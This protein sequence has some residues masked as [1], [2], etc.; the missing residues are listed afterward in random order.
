MSRESYCERL[1]PNRAARPPNWCRSTAS[2]MAHSMR[3]GRS[4]FSL[5][6]ERLED[7]CCLSA[8]GDISSAVEALPAI[9]E[10]QALALALNDIAE[11]TDGFIVTNRRHTASLTPTG[12]SMEAVDGGPQWHWQL[13]YVGSPT[14]ALSSVQLMQVTPE[15]DGQ[16]LVRYD[17]GTIVEQY[18]T[19]LDSIEQQFVIAEPL[20]L[21]GQDLVVAGTI[22]SDGTF[23]VVDNGWL[24]RTEMGVIRLGDVTVLDVTGSELEASMSVSAT[25]TRIVVDAA[26][27][28]DAVYPLL[29]DPEVGTND[30]RISD[31]GPGATEFIAQQPAV[32]YNSI[33]NQYLIVWS[34]DDFTNDEMEIFGQ[35]INAA[36]GAPVGPD[37]FRIS[38]VGIEG[39]TATGGFTP[40]VAYNS[41][42]NEYLVVW[43]E[44]NSNGNFEIAG[45]RISA[46]GDEIGSNDF[47]I[48]VTGPLGNFQFA[49]SNPD[50]AYNS[51]D[52]EYLVVW[53]ADDAGVLNEF[54][55]FGQRLNAATG[56]AVG[57]NDFR[58][59]DM[60]PNGNA[61]F[62]AYD[63]A[64]AY[65]STNNEYVVVWSGDDNTA[66]LVEEEFEI[67]RQRLSVTGVELG[68]N[69][70]RISDMGPNGSTN[71]EALRPDVV[72]NSTNNEYLVVWK[73]DDVTN[74]EYDIFGQRLNGTAA[75]IGT[76]DFR[77]SDMGPDANPFFDADRLSVTYSAAAN[78]YF[79]VWN[80]DDNTA[81]L[82][83]NEFEV[84]GQRLSGATGAAVGSNDFRIS[85]IGPN[86]NISLGAF[87][88]VVAF[89]STN[90]EYQVVWTADFFRDQEFEIFTQ[91]LIAATGVEVGTNDRRISDVGSE[92]QFVAW[93]TAIA[94]NSISNEY[95]VVW[96][97][98][99]TIPSEFEIYGQRI[100]ATTGAEVGVNDFRISDMGPDDNIFFFA[101]GPVVAFNSTN[102][103]YLVA[104]RGADDIAPL[105]FN[106]VEI[107]GQVLSA[108]GTELGANDFRISDMGPDG[109]TNFAVH[110]LAVAYNSTNNE[111]L[112]VWNGDDDTAPLVDNEI[113]VFGQ[114]IDAATGAE[115]GTNDFRI[116]D[117]GI[118][119]NPS[120]DAFTPDVAYN[121]T[122]NEYLVVW[123]GDD[124]SAPLVDNEIEV[125]GQRLVGATSGAIGTNDFRISDMGPN[126]DVLFGALEPAV[127]YN[128]TLN[129]YL[130]V[131]WGDDQTNN[132]FE[133]F[134]QR[135]G[136]G[137]GSAG[138]NDFQISDMG[139]D[140]DTGFGA[141]EP[142]VAYNSITQSYLVVWRGDDNTAPLINEEFEI[143]GQ[144]LSGLG[145]AVGANDVRLSDQGP[146]GDIDFFAFAPVVAASSTL[147]QF[148]VAWEGR[149]TG[150]VFGNGEREI[151]GQRFEAAGVGRSLASN[152]GLQAGRDNTIAILTVPLSTVSLSPANVRIGNS[153]HVNA[154][155]DIL[156]G[157][158][159]PQTSL[160]RGAPVRLEFARI[161]GPSSAVLRQPQVDL[162]IGT[163]V[164]DWLSQLSFDE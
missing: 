63:P 11:T 24:W 84:F 51:A 30:F 45:Q 64:V 158:P 79:V 164:R 74:S 159:S 149:E 47:G 38:N 126:G 163:L 58:I 134:G 41:T 147:N 110:N 95:L 160:L 103:Q 3:G 22:Q 72:H 131:W 14:A 31:M 141:F 113:E 105:A 115:V 157:W 50:V 66:P 85:D 136:A 40:A 32:A 127:A 86:G 37:D 137:G 91:R 44:D 27:L 6:F 148:L 116:S 15:S 145:A 20:A 55:I 34:G 156:K 161:P 69:D 100:N 71:F 93:D 99:D 9:T 120:F 80:G 5:A 67:F 111:Y 96:S 61:A 78:E 117:M 142:A 17:R 129:Q 2:R 119:G 53:E 107:F 49:A 35:L 76:N 150:G 29:I 135:L 143:F 153:V 81:P 139:P 1:Q 94:F 70:F 59:S 133:I 88:P 18:V 154:Q 75:N 23:E 140:G 121:S 98:N 118:D 114:R 68:A 162:L 4:S 62:D 26:A 56:S 89:N 112:V 92:G 102:N 39:N 33:D 8:F 42:N 65:N 123:H 109:S 12:F 138:T 146:D 128:N 82:F 36:T 108:T 16:S 155:P 77:I 144:E 21:G 101:R 152:A 130:V 13:N 124:N 28:R 7:R 54:E 104:W 52:N 48:S 73:G 19:Q 90:N 60:G 106:E 46:T 87:Q 97:G 122:N 132:D 10:Q 83:D 43:S 25:E 125:F 57:V 151:F